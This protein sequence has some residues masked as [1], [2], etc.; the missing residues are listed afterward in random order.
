MKL[1]GTQSM[2]QNANHPDVIYYDTP[3][4]N[5]ISILYLGAKLN[6]F[7]TPEKCEMVL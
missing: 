3:I 4:K 1:Y 7:L 2:L 6:T 5:C